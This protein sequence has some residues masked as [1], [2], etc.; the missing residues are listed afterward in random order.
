MNRYSDGVSSS[1]KLFPLEDMLDDEEE[2]DD[3]E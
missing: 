2:D 3:N 1:G